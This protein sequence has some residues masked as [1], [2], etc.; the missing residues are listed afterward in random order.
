GRPGE[1]G[2]H[3][4]PLPQAPRPVG[5]PAQ[6]EKLKSQSVPV[7]KLPPP[8]FFASLVSLFH[9]VLSLAPRLTTDDLKIPGADDN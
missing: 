1:P 8:P 5:C 9:I 6:T 7:T 3:L 2:W 4:A